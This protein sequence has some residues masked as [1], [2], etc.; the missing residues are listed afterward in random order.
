[1]PRRNYNPKSEAKAVKDEA[2]EFS[3]DEYNPIT[4]KDIVSLNEE[5]VDIVDWEARVDEDL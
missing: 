4:E 1:M 3:V 2:I 5:F